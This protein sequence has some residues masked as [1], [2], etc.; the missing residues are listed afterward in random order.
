MGS[1]C[2][3]SYHEDVLATA[4]CENLENYDGH[5]TPHNPLEL[6]AWSGGGKETA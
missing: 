4:P 2:G 5:L 6:E 3:G 1:G